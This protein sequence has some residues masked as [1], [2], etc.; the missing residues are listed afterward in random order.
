L[1]RQL[2]ARPNRTRHT[3]LARGV[4][5]ARQQ[6]LQHH[7]EQRL[8]QAALV[9]RQAQHQQERELP[10]RLA[11]VLGGRQASQQHLLVWWQG[12]AHTCRTH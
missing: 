8:K 10:Y 5:A 4:A 12:R 6:R 2:P 7:V 1:K 9:L 3:H 11:A